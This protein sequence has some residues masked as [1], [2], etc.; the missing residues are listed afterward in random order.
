MVW[1]NKHCS[2]RDVVFEAK[3]L[4]F[5]WCKARANMLNSAPIVSN[6]PEPYRWTPPEADWIK[7][8]VDAAVFT[9]SGAIS[10]VMCNQYGNF[11]GGFAVKIDHIIDSSVLELM[12]IL[13]ALTWLKDR[14][15]SR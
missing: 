7:L 13:E 6:T 14:Q 1:E 5:S 11:V 9:S 12:A 2:V 8:N 3:N 4:L 10:V 15:W